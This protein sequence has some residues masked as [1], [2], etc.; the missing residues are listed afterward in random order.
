MDGELR[1]LGAATADLA[2]PLGRRFGRF[3]HAARLEL[4][5]AIEPLEPRH[6]LT[7]GIVLCPEPGSVFKRLHQQRLQLFEAK[8]IDGAG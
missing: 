3:L 6:L 4:G 2:H 8:P 1:S 7:Q 5:A